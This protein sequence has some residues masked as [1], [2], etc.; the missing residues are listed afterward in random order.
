LLG[1]GLDT[2]AYRQPSWT[3]TLHIFEVDHPATQPWKR[4]LLKQAGISLP[5]NLSFVPT[6]F[7][8]VSLATALSQARM[9]NSEPT[10]FSMLG[11]SQ[12]LACTLT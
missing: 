7:E 3:D 6:D 8:E 10:F 2:F 11:V 4:T 12:Y 1:A 9:D 5:A